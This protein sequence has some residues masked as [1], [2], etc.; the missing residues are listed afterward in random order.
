M[1]A[2]VTVFRLRTNGLAQISGTDGAPVVQPAYAAVMTLN[3]REAIVQQILGVAATS[4]ICTINAASG[5]SFG[6]S[7]LLIL[8]DTGGVTYTLGTNFKTAGGTIN[9]TTGKK[10]VVEFLS[11]GVNFYDIGRSTA[12]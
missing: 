10:V 2:E 9:P 1:S 11:D 12:V 4:A 6:Q 5:G 8:A 7:L 3:T